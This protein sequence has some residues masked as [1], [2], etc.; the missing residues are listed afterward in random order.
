MESLKRA[1]YARETL[2]VARELVG[3]KLVRQVKGHTL[4]GMIIETE[5][6]LGSTD[7]ASH[8]YKRKTPR[9]RI[10][11]GPAGVAYVYFVYGM[12]HLLNVVT[13]SEGTP[14]AVLIRALFPLEGKDRMA[15]LRGVGGKQITNGPAKL[16]QAFAIDKSL[17]GW[18]LTKEKKLW[19]ENFKEI[20]SEF[21]TTGPRVGIHYA[22]EKDRNAPWRMWVKNEYLMDSQE[23][24]SASE[25]R[26]SSF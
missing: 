19:V 24:Q 6:Y 16:C 18:D 26:Q 2:T 21:V 25:Q 5:A 12:H 4:S 15:M 8:A 20:P 9:N 23:I 13:E 22:D 1:F 17:N 10:M 7:S 14:C 3:K 11:F